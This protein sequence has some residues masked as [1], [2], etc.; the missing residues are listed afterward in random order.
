M[1]KFGDSLWMVGQWNN[2]IGQLNMLAGFSEER[3]DTQNDENI[4]L[5]RK[6]H[7]A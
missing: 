6:I 4:F 7:A 3:A 2:W 5:K 1:L